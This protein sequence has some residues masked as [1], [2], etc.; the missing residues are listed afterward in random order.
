MNRFLIGLL[1]G[2]LPSATALLPRPQASQKVVQPQVITENQK[3]R[4]VRWVLQPGEGTPIHAHAL[5]HVS[6]VIR[7]SAIR[8]VATDGSARTIEQRTGDATYVPATGRSHS[9][10]NAGQAVY[11][12]VSIEL[13]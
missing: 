12:S 9:F 4:M 8:D 3:V 7:G 10:A 11:E 2:L 1:L 6:V 13:K 5:D